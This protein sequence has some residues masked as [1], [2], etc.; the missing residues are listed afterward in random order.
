M[1]SVT[2]WIACHASYVSF[3]GEGKPITC[4]AYLYLVPVL[5]DELIQ[6][7]RRNGFLRLVNKITGTPFNLF[8][9]DFIPYCSNSN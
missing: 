8:S 2:H 9:M 4:Q 5:G 6:D 1:G 3:T 7:R